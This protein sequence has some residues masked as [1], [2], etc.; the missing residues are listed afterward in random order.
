MGPLSSVRVAIDTG[1][2]ELDLAIER[3]HDGAIFDADGRRVG[4]LA[5]AYRPP[6]PPRPPTPATAYQAAARGLGLTC[7]GCKRRQLLEAMGWAQAGQETERVASWL[8]ELSEQQDKPASRAECR[9]AWLAALK[10]VRA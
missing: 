5:F 2:G 8:V 1:S 10:E 4:T 6:T 9:A 7:N 3:D